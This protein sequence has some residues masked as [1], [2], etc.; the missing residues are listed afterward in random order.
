[1]PWIFI[2]AAI[3][4]A[5]VFFNRK[6]SIEPALEQ[7][8]HITG[9]TIV[10][11]WKWGF[12]PAL[13]QVI[14]PDTA[15]FYITANRECCLW[16]EAAAM[17]GAKDIY[18]SDTRIMTLGKSATGDAD[19]DA[20]FSTGRHPHLKPGPGQNPESVSADFKTA[21]MALKD[22]IC[23]KTTNRYVT[24]SHPEGTQVAIVKVENFYIPKTD[25]VNVLV[26]IQRKM[27][28]VYRAYIQFATT[29][30]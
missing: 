8:G 27:V 23:K 30:D 26:D 25:P 29:P 4:L 10:R 5:A 11:S 9:G 6:M 19:F 14:G 17:K 3:L 24:F 22:T 1:M 21:L 13:K 20:V 12:H 2:A 28:A 18:V 16:V 7:I 15:F